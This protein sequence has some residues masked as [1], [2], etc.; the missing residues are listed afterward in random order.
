VGGESRTRKVKEAMNL[1]KACIGI[2]ESVQ[3]HGMIKTEKSERHVQTLLAKETPRE[4]MRAI[5]RVQRP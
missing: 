1:I 5:Q 4:K 3:S 2:G